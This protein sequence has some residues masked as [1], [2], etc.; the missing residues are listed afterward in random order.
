MSS[1]TTTM[2]IVSSVTSGL[3]MIK[4]ARILHDINNELPWYNDYLSI[5]IGGVGLLS[6]WD[7]IHCIAGRASLS[8]MKFCKM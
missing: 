3:L 6:L 2:D 1:Q 8:K 7:G 5:I 4:G